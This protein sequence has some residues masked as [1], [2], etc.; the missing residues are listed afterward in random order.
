MYNGKPVKMHYFIKCMDHY[1]N[2]MTIE[3]IAESWDDIENY[4]ETLKKQGYTV[5]R[6][7]MAFS[8]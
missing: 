2:R 5:L 4:K 1:G 6:A 7:T 8:A 3:Y